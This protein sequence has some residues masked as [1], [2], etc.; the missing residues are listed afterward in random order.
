[1]HDNIVTPSRMR[2]HLEAVTRA[3]VWILRLFQ[4]FQAVSCFHF[5]SCPV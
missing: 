1:M 5:P 2:F 4:K 3:C